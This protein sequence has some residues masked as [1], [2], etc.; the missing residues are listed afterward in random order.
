MTILGFFILNVANTAMVVKS[1]RSLNQRKICTVKPC[2]NH[3]RS[4]CLTLLLKLGFKLI[5]NICRER[6]SWIS[7]SHCFIPSTLE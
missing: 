2:F 7:K 1:K 5:T 4:K 3:D 6:E